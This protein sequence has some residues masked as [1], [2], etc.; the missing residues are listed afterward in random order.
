DAGRDLG[1]VSPPGGLVLQIRLIDEPGGGVVVIG[2]EDV[3]AVSTAKGA[4]VAAGTIGGVEPGRE[5]IQQLVTADPVAQLQ[6]EPVLRVRR[7]DDVTPQVD[8]DRA[9]STGRQMV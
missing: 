9:E 4:L 5:R 2:T 1:T 6:D 7:Q 3:P 8:V